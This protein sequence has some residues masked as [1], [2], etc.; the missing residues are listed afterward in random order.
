MNSLDRQLFL[1]QLTISIKLL[2]IRNIIFNYI[3]S[4]KITCKK[5]NKLKKYNKF[6]SYQKKECL[7]Q[8]KCNYCT[9]LNI[10]D[11]HHFML[12]ILCSN[13]QMD[14]NYSNRIQ[15]LYPIYKVSIL[16][17]PFFTFIFNEEFTSWLKIYKNN[18]LKITDNKRIRSDYFNLDFDSKGYLLIPDIKNPSFISENLIIQNEHKN[19]LKVDTLILFCG[20]K[21]C[22]RHYENSDYKCYLATHDDYPYEYFDAINHSDINVLTIDN[23]FKKSPHILYSFYDNGHFLINYLLNNNYSNIKTVI[24]EGFDMPKIYTSLQNINVKNVYLYNGNF[25]SI[26]II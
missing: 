2:E 25:K 6:S 23:D 10:T 13:K 17:N 4:Y 20:K 16:R 11:K 9:K 24:F 15:Q 22:S 3:K 26:K 12:I 1:N 8:I 19:P 21:I 14:K 18:F 5:C 7:Q